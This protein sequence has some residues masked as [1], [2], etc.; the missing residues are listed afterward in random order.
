MV[1]W[2]S[3]RASREFLYVEDAAR[4]VALAV[5]RYEGGDPVNIGAG[6]EI[7]IRDLVAKIA[8]MVGFAG[9]VAWDASKPDGQP[10]RCLDTRR[11][12]EFGF[13][14]ST[15]FDDGL[16]RTIDWWSAQAASDSPIR[17]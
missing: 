5:E 12:R 1:V 17:P 11:A 10:R 14:A 6:F 3:G 16:R 7:T 13:E 4:A 15:S 8:Q 9:R 2:G